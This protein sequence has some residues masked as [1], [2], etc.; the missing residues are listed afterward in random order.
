M[1]PV[2]EKP[3]GQQ[4]RYENTELPDGVLTFL[5]ELPREA[6]LDEG[7]MARAFGVS[8][9]TIRRMVERH[10]LPPS[11]RNAGKSMWF[12]GRVLDWIEAR[13]EEREKAA[14]EAMA[15]IARFSP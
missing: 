13:A 1:E 15:R 8:E 5:A 9:R 4:V 14:K 11:V 2:N 12:A 6:L 7:A 3:E 10:E